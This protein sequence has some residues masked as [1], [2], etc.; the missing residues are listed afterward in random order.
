MEDKYAKLKEVLEDKNYP[1][2]YPFKLIFEKDEAK[3]IQIK[4]VFDETAEISKRD[5]KNGKYISIT[6]KQMMMNSEDII[7]R[8]RH[9]EEI[10]GVITL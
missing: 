4:R 6:I 2:I 5:S 9:M 8:Y 10:E 3:M 1:L 7:T